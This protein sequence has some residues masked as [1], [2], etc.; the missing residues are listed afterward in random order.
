MNSGS[1]DL[2]SDSVDIKEL[3]DSESDSNSIDSNSSGGGQRSAQLREAVNP[4]HGSASANIYISNKKQFPHQDADSGGLL[5]PGIDGDGMAYDNSVIDDS[6]CD[7]DGEGM[8]VLPSDMT[9]LLSL[10]DQGMCESGVKKTKATKIGA[11]TCIY[12]Y[13]VYCKN[14]VFY[15]GA[16][17][18]GSAF[19]N[20]T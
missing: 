3:A 18:L 12:N 5:Y 4:I 17:A 9:R 2:S 1:I 16:Y 20:R 6:E 7:D 11:C 10:N 13:Y 14:L 19:T 8:D 15:V